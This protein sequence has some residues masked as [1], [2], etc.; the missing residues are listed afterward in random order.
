MNSSTRYSH[1]VS[2][3]VAISS[4]PFTSALS[5]L[6]HGYLFKI[7]V[8]PQEFRPIFTIITLTLSSH[9]AF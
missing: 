7:P 3:E 2:A 4:G 5:H 9:V 6:Y 1:E 8:C